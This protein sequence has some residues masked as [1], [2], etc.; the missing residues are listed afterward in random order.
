[1]QGIAG[2]CERRYSWF[3]G[4]GPISAGREH[5]PGG[6]GARVARRRRNARPSGGRQGNTDG[7]TRH[8]GRPDPPRTH[9]SRGQGHRPDRPP[10]R[11]THLR[12]RG[13]RRPVVDRHGT[14][15]RPLAGT[16]PGG[17][18]TARRPRDGTDRSRTGGGATAGARGRRPAPGHQTGERAGGT[19]GAPRGPH[20]LRHRRDPGRRGA[21]HGR[22]A[23]GS[24]GLHG[25]GADL[26]PPAGSAVGRVVPR[27]DALRGPRRA[28]AVLPL[29]DPGDTAR[30]AVR[31]TATAPLRSGVDGDPGRPPGQ[32]T[33][34]AAGA[35]GGRGGTGTGR[36]GRH[37]CIGGR[38]VRDLGRRRGARR[39]RG[40]RRAGAGT[41]A[42]R[43]VDDRGRPGGG[44]ERHPRLPRPGSGPGGAA[45]PG[46]R[47]ERRESV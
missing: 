21:H 32:G 15:G 25:S 36:R 5:R 30:R 3:I 2:K 47:G 26:G 16:N 17:G 12:R 14:R 41:G 37:R 34:R 1:M 38:R 19:P 13:R 27:R 6:N 22:D 33:G 46:R 39:G 8:G 31:G 45:P 40:G 11:R 7:R 44:G 10:Q 42:R 24:P 23:G 43:R 35:R 18:G 9:P 20:G 28:L 4:D 29:D